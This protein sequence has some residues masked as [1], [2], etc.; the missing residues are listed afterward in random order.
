MDDIGETVYYKRKDNLIW[1]GSAAV[2]GKYGQQI[3]VKDN[4]NY[5]V[6]VIYNSGIITMLVF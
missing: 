2:T 4:S 5:I 6:H 1:K 3:S